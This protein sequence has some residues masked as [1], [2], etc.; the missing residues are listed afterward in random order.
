MHVSLNDCLTARE[1]VFSTL[2]DDELVLFDPRKGSYFGAGLVGAAIWR[3]LTAD[4]SVEEI[5]V[6]L[7][8]VFSVDEATCKHDVLAFLNEAYKRGLVVFCR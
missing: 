6:E 7:T 3:K 1:D 4:K 5:C 8:E 2:V